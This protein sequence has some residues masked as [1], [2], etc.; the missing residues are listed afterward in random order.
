MIQLDELK[1]A[2]NNIHFHLAYFNIEK[3]NPSIT[4]LGYIPSSQ[5]PTILHNINLFEDSKGNKC[6]F[7]YSIVIEDDDSAIIIEVFVDSKLLKHFL[8]SKKITYT[9][10]NSIDVRG[11]NISCLQKRVIEIPN[12]L[13]KGYIKKLMELMRNPKDEKKAW[14]TYT[15]K[16]GQA[17][18]MVIIDNTFLM[19]R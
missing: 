18:H 8:T 16:Y 17:S 6:T 1:L 11:D 15:T 5:E 3:N 2:I 19:K 10:C 14:K 13:K 4:Y 12:R 7:F 9:F